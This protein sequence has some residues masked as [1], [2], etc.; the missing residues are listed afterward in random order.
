MFLSKMVLRYAGILVTFLS[1]S[2]IAEP[3]TPIGGIAIVAKLYR[4]FA[5]EALIDEPKQSELELLNQPRQVLSQYFNNNL[6]SLLLKDRECQRKTHEICNLDFLPIWAG[7]DP[8]AYQLKVLAT[9][10]PNIVSVNF[11]Y[12]SNGGKIELTYRVTK[13]KEGWRVGDIIQQ[14]GNSLLSDLSRKP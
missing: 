12:P 14:S 6:V 13:T 3:P 7:Q 2:A 5:W 9:S 1:S 8:G 4:D 10:N 11:L